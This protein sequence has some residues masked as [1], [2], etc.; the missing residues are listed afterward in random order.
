MAKGITEA[1]VG[2]LVLIALVILGFMFYKLGG[3]DIGKANGYEVKA[4][5]DSAA[6]LREEGQVQIAGINVGAIKTIAL[7]GKRARLTMAIIPEVK[8]PIDSMAVIRTQGVLGD[9]YVEIIPGSLGLPV[10]EAGGQIAKTGTPTDVDKIL[11]RIGEVSE[12]IK[13]VTGSLGD[14]VGGDQ[15]KEDLKRII[16]NFAILSENLARLTQEN[17]EQMN[18]MIE[19]LTVFSE[20]LRTMSSANKDNVS[21]MLT[22]IRTASEN[23]NQTIVALQSITAKINNGEGTVGRLVNDD[24]TV[25]ELNT[26]LASLKDISRKIN[27]G[28]GTIGQLVNDNKAATEL[29]DA[30]EGVNDYLDKESTFKVYVD[31]R[32][33]WLTKPEKMRSVLNIKIQPN[34]DKYYLVGIVSDP[35]GEYERIDRRYSVDGQQTGVTTEEKWS[36]SSLKFNA[37][38]AK[39]Y[40]DL[41]IRGGLIES[42][43]GAGLDYYFLDDDLMLTFEAATG[44]FDR[45]PYLNLGMRYDFWKFFYLTAGYSDL[46]SDQDHDS[47][48]VGFGLSFNDDDLKYIMGKV[49]LPN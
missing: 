12:D 28:E 43:G 33:E 40:Y 31:Y 9:K 8:L 25:D 30:L 27:E 6:G 41:V 3:F 37:Q 29:E 49:P 36:R 10:I 2:G 15:G 14:V 5:F 26:T 42:R 22:T 35:W 47:G 13:D 39:R 21:A 11:N 20:D 44:D 19:N 18:R 48:Y 17:S 24:T 16:T 38:L 46:I 32:A 23:L 1:K 45:N 4:I 7:E 34:E